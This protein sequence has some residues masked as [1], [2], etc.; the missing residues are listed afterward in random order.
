MNILI[1]V[2][3]RYS[4]PFPVRPL[5]AIRKTLPGDFM[6]THMNVIDSTS[7]GLPFLPDMHKPA[8]KIGM[9]SPL[10][11]YAP[12]IRRMLKYTGIHS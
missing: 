1:V 3:N 11:R 5:G 12:E 8:H 7:L 6:K 9:K 10:G 4:N 2:T